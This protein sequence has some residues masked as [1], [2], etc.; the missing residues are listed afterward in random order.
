M[1]TASRSIPILKPIGRKHYVYA[2]EEYE[3]AFPKWQIEAIC[4]AWESGADIHSI[5]KQNKR[6]AVEV[7]IAIF[8][9][10]LKGNVKRPFIEL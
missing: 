10:Y 7:F 8:D 5:S 1:K 4:K 6:P 9:Q 2:L 3:L